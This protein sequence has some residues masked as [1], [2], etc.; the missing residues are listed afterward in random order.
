MLNQ[1]SDIQWESFCHNCGKCCYSKYDLFLFAIADPS[2]VCKYLTSDNRCEIYEDRLSKNG[3]ISLREAIT[4]SG[5]LPKDC[6]YIHLN[7]EHKELIFPKSEE[8]FWE[9]INFADRLLKKT[10]K[11][12]KIDLV[13]FVLERRGK[14]PDFKLLTKTG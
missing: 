4:R 5:L 13:S 12:Q 9:F 6:G 3:C 1:I 8:E 10:I 2:Y 14:N 7:P 11:G